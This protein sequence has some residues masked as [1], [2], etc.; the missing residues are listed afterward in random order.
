MTSYYKD[1]G[2]FYYKSNKTKELISKIRKNVTIDAGGLIVG[3]IGL[4]IML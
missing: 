2:M 3:L 1:S 4:I